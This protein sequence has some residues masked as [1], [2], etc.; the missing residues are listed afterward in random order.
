MRSLVLLLVTLALSSSPA[1]ATSLWLA[2]YTTT[3]LDDEDAARLREQIRME[4]GAV[5]ASATSHD[6]DA[7]CVSAPG[8]VE[9][10]LRAVGASAALEVELVRAGPLL[11][12]TTRLHRPERG[13][14]RAEQRL[15]QLEALERGGSLLGDA[16]LDELGASKASDA[17]PPD[18]EARDGPSGPTAAEPDEALKEPLPDDA[19]S[20]RPPFDDHP[21]SGAPSEPTEPERGEGDVPVLAVSGVGL[22]AGGLLAV[23][24]GAGI[25]AGGNAVLLDPRSSAGDKALATVYGPLA[26]VATV[27][28]GAATLAGG[29]LLVVGLA[30]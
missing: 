16:L 3:G 28:G 2:G 21:A 30:E 27:A 12:V 26:I 1:A 7:A 20:E 6:P 18:A 9:S 29:T 15:V 25:A 5:G 22:T 19:T 14:P 4:L 10:R 24:I 23:V 8:C 11:Q 13:E 17:G